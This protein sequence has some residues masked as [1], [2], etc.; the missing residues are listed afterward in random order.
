MSPGGGRYVVVVVVVV[1]SWTQVV[2]LRVQSIVSSRPAYNTVRVVKSL[3][4]SDHS[5]VVAYVDRPPPAHKTTVQQTYRRV[6]PAQHASFL[7]YLSTL[8]IDLSHLECDLQGKF[9]TF[10]EI[11]NSLLNYY[12]YPLCTI[13]VTSRDPAF[14]TP[15]IKS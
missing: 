13:T 8:H 11:A 7:Q 5:A 9:D 3:V 2:D 6:S 4:R 14:V 15:S 12:F 10:Y 1:V